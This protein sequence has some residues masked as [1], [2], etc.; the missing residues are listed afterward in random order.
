MS[1]TPEPLTIETPERELING[2]SS[3]SAQKST[4]SVWLPPVPGHTLVDSVLFNFL[5]LSTGLL[6]HGSASFV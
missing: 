1:N 4:W 3:S 2:E 5:L 6:T